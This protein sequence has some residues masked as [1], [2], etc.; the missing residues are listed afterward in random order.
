MLMDNLNCRLDAWDHTARDHKCE[1][2]EKF[3]ESSRHLTIENP[4]TLTFRCINDSFVKDFSVTYF[5]CS[6][7]ITTGFKSVPFPLRKKARLLQ[8]VVFFFFSLQSHSEWST[9]LTIFVHLFNYFSEKPEIVGSILALNHKF[10]MLPKVDARP[11][12]FFRLIFFVFFRHYATFFSKIFGFYQRVTPCIF[13]KF[14][15]CKNV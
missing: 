1:L 11:K 7:N 3:I 4:C 15:V 12:V 14:S 13:L 8:W 5:T 2:L 6:E 10:L 9:F